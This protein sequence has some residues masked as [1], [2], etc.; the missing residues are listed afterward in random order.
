[1]KW[2]SSLSENPRLDAAVRETAARIKESMDGESVDFLSVFLSRHFA[3]NYDAL[4][5]LLAERFPR[6]ILIGCGAGGVI[7]DGLEIEHKP[8]LSLLAGRL[9]GVKIKP[10]IVHDEDLPDLDE[11]PKAWERLVGVRAEEDPHFILLLDPFSIRADD[12]LRGLDYAFPRAAKVG[13]LAS[14]AGEPQK[15][16]LY[17]NTLCLRSGV[18]G[19]AFTGNIRLDTVVAQGCKPIGP[20]LRVTACRDN[21]LL[22]LDHHPPLSVLQKLVEDVSDEDRALLRDSLFLGMALSPMTEGERAGEF[23]IRNIIGADNERGTLAIGAPLRTGQ[24]VRFHVRDAKSSAQ[25]L[26]NCLTRFASHGGEA[27]GAILVSCLGRGRRLY[28]KSHHDSQ[29]F[30][31][32]LGP[33]P[34]GGFFANGEIGPVDG[35]TYLHGYTSCFG[36]FSPQTA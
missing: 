34:L 13:G 16:A 33:L 25:D 1:M 7:G 3:D 19:V 18:V 10:F 24:K 27:R 17:L 4:N 29:L 28:G 21:V 22:E 9:P 12:F 2:A 11:S 26:Q 8:A 32:R 14:G 30:R 31:Q 35:S 6:A 20:P 5:S 15:N 36:V 23:L